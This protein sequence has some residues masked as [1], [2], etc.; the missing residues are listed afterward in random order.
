VVVAVPELDQLVGRWT[1][2]IRAIVPKLR[3][4]DA[5]GLSLL[6]GL[7]KSLR[8]VDQM[9]RLQAIDVEQR[10]AAEAA[11]DRGSRFGTGWPRT[12]AG[13]GSPA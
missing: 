4:G 3:P 10:L 6:H 5:D 7:Q 9:I 13:Y 8:R 12:A 1:E 2:E 11:C